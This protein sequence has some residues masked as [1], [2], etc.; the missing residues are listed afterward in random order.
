MRSRHCHAA[1]AA[2][3]LLASSLPATA[4]P[5]ANCDKCFAL[6]RNNGTLSQ[7][8]NV[9]LNYRHATG[10]YEIVFK[11]PISKCVITTQPEMLQATSVIGRASQVGNPANR[12]VSIFTVGSSGETIDVPFGIYILC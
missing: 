5:P 9:S 11:Y 2:V 7:S 4:A 1:L 6:V 12:S 8:R 3:S 10:S